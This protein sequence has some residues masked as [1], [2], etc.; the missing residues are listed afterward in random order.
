MLLATER[1]AIR[2]LTLEDA[3]F[4]LELLNE[5]SFLRNIGDRGVRSVVDARRY[6][7]AGPLASYH[8]HGF[9]LYRVELG[10]SGEPIGICGLLRR[11]QL[12][13]VDLGFALL[14]RFWGRGYAI[15]AA[16]RV[17]RHAWEDVALLRVVAIT[18]PDNRGSIRV[19]ES[20]GMTFEGT[21]PWDEDGA[22]LRL[23]AIE[24]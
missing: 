16:R 10:D 21:V 14:P 2:R 5:P 23:Y 12:D 17:L 8:A 1:L 24:R 19:L 22:E 18:T 20:L 11:P 15:E 4:L 9:G 3:P 13:D 7:E 6:L